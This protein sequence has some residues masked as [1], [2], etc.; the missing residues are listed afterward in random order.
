MWQVIN[1]KTK[2]ILYEGFT[3]K[4]CLN[5]IDVVYKGPKDNLNIVV[6]G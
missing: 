6:K 2:E 4:Q 1:V 3:Y 5:F